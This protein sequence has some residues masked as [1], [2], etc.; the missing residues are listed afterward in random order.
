[1]AR[2][3]H[4]TCVGEGAAIIQ[5]PKQPVRPVV[6]RS[7]YETRKAALAVHDARLIKSAKEDRDDWVARIV[8]AML[9]DM[10]PK[11]AQMLEFRLLG[12]NLDCLAATQALALV[13]FHNGRRARGLN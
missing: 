4:N 5:F 3:I 7:A 2:H 11:Q 12:Q 1:M 10:A 6:E 8:L 9:Q 13:Q